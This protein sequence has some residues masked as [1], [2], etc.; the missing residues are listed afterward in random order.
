[1]IDY[2]KKIVGSA[3]LIVSHRDKDYSYN[4]TKAVLT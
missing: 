2:Y 4:L 1:M 3:R